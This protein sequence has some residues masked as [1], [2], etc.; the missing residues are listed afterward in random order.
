MLLSLM[1]KTK[2]TKIEIYFKR[3]LKKAAQL[4]VSTPKPDH[5]LGSHKRTYL[6]QIKLQNKQ[7]VNYKKIRKIISTL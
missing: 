5:K 2:I 3:I 7:F 6:R 4:P 1:R